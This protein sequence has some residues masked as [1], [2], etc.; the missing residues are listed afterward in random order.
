MSYWPKIRPTIDE[1]VNQQ[2]DTP[3]FK[4]L[5][6]VPLTRKRIEVYQNHMTFY[7]N[8]RRDCWAFVAGKAPLDV[9]RA[10][11]AHEKDELIH[12][13]RMGRAH[14]TRLTCR[15]AMSHCWLPAPRRLTMPGYIAP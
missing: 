14:V 12:D 5:F 6:A 8:N 15:P 2:F 13:E 9:K 4:K 3:E 7:A 11:W 1:M 10:I